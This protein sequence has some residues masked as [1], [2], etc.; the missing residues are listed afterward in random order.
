MARPS[1]PP[2]LDYS[3]YTWRRVQI[4]KLL[5]MQLSPT[6]SCTIEQIT[7]NRPTSALQWNR[8]D[9]KSRQNAVLLQSWLNYQTLESSP[10]C[11]VLSTNR[12]RVLSVEWNTVALRCNDWSTKILIFNCWSERD[13]RGGA[14]YRGAR[15][16]LTHKIDDTYWEASSIRR[17]GCE[18]G[19][20]AIAASTQS[21]FLVDHN[22]NSRFT[23]SIKPE[24]KANP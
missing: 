16:G 5:V 9:T 17:L 18:D 22:I 7:S 12:K 15:I 6:T 20:E 23:A 1:H 24:T 2:R 19:G 21:T 11:N 3:N 4:M 13:V 14:V 10:S 8:R